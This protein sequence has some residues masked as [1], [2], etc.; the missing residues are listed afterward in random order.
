MEA[1]REVEVV[2]NKTNGLH[3]RF[4]ASLIAKLQS[5]IHDTRI[6]TKIYVIHRERKTPI[7]SLLA[8]ISYKIQKGEKII[9]R[10]EEEV[11]QEII[12]KIKDF[13]QTPDYEESQDHSKTDQ[14]LMEN[15]VTVESVLSSLPNGIVVVNKENIITYVN[16]EAV[17]LFEIPLDQLLNHRADHVIPHSRLYHV[18]Q[19][20]IAEIAKKQVLNNRVILTNRSPVIWDGKIV[21]AVALFHDISTIEELSKELNE[22]KKIKEQL[23]LVLHSVED[24]IAL[25]D[26]NGDF[27]YTNPVMEILLKELDKTHSIFQVLNKKVWRK[28]VDY[29]RPFV[30]VVHLENHHAYIAKLHPILVDGCFCGTVLTLS[31]LNEIKTL[32]QQLEIAEERTRYL[33]QELSKHERFNGAFAQIIGYSDELMDTLS[34]ANKVAKTDSTILITGESGTGKELVARAIHEASDRNGKPFIRV[35]CAAI[36]AHLIESELFGHEKGAF[37]GAFQLRRGKFEL[38]HTGTILLDEIGDLSL[39]LQSK[40]LRVL[41]EKE[42][43]RVGGQQVIHL[44][45]RVIAATHRDLFKM[46]KTGEFREDLFY[47]LNV[48]PIHLPPLRQRKSDIPLLVDSFRKQLNKSLGKNIKGYEKG[49]MEALIQYDWPGNIRELQNIVE[50]TMSLSEGEY[51]LIKDLPKYLI[52]SQLLED[53]PSIISNEWKKEGKVKTMEEYEREIFQYAIQ[54]YPSFNSVSKALGLTHKTVASKV[55]KYGLEDY[56]GKKYQ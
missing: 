18:M 34:I 11:S 32:L 2:V 42:I 36:P 12:E 1:I 37:T 9:L 38:A 55:R 13:I 44:D 8:L 43:E 26:Q 4:A 53:D 30:E 10:F 23:D 24:A 20:G 47:R 48:I 14:L 31:P 28:V 6:L 33:E 51:L 15:S 52:S 16:E 35:N 54:Y 22:V 3:V 29:H 50:R 41:Q 49:F 25:S 56:L 17:K 46:V 21:G 5:L 7:T 45:V 39:E 40:I 27:L 19:T